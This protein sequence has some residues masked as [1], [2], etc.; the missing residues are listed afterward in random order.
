[1]PQRY[2][3][4]V[5]DRAIKMVLPHLDEYPSVYAAARALAPRLGV[6]PETLRRWVV[7]ASQSPRSAAEA[8][9]AKAE[10]KRVRDL[11]KENRDLR[12]ANEILKAASIFFAG[13]LDPRRR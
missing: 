4:Q 1:M 8:E 12:A 6:G 7:A 11:E 10:S 9:A 5:K 2:P 3:E 13:E